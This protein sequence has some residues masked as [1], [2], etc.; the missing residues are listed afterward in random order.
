[1]FSGMK[2]PGLSS[3]AGELIEE[4]ETISALLDPCCHEDQLLWLSI[5]TA[6]LL[7]GLGGP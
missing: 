7:H 2:Q 4:G 1:M 5:H 6:H 3:D